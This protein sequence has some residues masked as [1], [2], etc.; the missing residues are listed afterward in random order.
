MKDKSNLYKLL[1]TKPEGKRWLGRICFCRKIT[2]K[3]I[4]KK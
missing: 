2:H 3:W 4:A 1:A